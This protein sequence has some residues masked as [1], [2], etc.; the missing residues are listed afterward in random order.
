MLKRG[1]VGDGSMDILEVCE[2]HATMLE[3]GEVLLHCAIGGISLAPI[4]GV[5]CLGKP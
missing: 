2:Y 4:Y 3:P 5:E 1:E